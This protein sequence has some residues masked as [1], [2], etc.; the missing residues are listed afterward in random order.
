MNFNGFTLCYLPENKN[1]T[2]FRGS[3]VMKPLNFQNSFSLIKTNN[4]TNNLNQP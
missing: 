3:K 2:I 4:L 1:D